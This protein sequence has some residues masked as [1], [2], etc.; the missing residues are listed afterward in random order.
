MSKVLEF[1]L[2]SILITTLTIAF[3][4]FSALHYILEISGITD[5]VWHSSA[6]TWIDSNGDGLVNNGEPPLSNVEIHINDVKNQL[7]N[8]GWHATTNMYGDAQLNVLIP[9]C[10]DTVFEVY[11]D[12]PEGYRMTTRPRIEVNRDFW[13]SLGTESIYSFGFIPKK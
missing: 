11:A 8:V 2:G 5:C 7:V 12:T 3:L 10:S 6:R 13:G 9:N 1:F 4:F